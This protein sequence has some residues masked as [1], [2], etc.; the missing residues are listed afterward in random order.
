MGIRSL[1]YAC[2]DRCALNGTGVAADP[3]RR[4]LTATR[5][6]YAVTTVVRL[7]SRRAASFRS[8]VVVES[9]GRGPVSCRAEACRQARRTW[10]DEDNRRIELGS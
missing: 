1:P 9:E 3:C 7:T 6:R 2:I 8:G 4:G 5:S 10:D